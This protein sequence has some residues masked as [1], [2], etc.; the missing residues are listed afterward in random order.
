MIQKPLKCKNEIIPRITILY[1][2]IEKRKLNSTR[3][4]NRHLNTVQALLKCK[5]LKYRETNLFANLNR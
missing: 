4:S 3:N 5:K 2:L 1:S